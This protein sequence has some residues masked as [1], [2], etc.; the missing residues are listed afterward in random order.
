MN[1][2]VITKNIEE[3]YDFASRVVQEL[4]HETIVLCLRGELGS[5]KTTFTQG[6]LRMCGAPGPFT[7][8]TFTIMKEYPTTHGFFEKIY[9]IDAYR[10]NAQDMIE[11]GWQ[12]MITEK[13]ALI[14]VE[15]PEQIAQ[16]I[17]H[18]ARRIDCAW[19]GES[20]RKYTMI[21]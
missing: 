12:D 13:N 1:T 16:I 5:G 10:I 2:A 15:W 3:T 17:P 11:L 18:N 4:P 6:V 8:P 19:V 20:Q 21:N 7:S 9:H 14:I